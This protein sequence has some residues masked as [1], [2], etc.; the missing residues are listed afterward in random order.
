MNSKHF[1]KHIF[2][3]VTI[4]AGFTA[5]TTF[6]QDTVKPRQ[7]IKEWLTV[8]FGTLVKMK[9]EIIDGEELNDKYHQSSFLFRI[10]SVD[11]ILLPK[12]IIIDFKDET[13]KFPTDEFELYKYLYGKEIG[14]I[15][16]SGS[17]K[18]K[19]KYVGQEFTIVA[20]EAGEFGGVPD[21][22]FRYQPVR[23]DFGFYFRHYIIVVADLTKLTD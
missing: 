4:I 5:K 14:K 22:Y 18:M 6:G 17:K 8:P 7:V 19:K 1:L 20:Y 9:V 23:Q 15:S 2:F 13:G 21:G 3:T 10:K 11:S 16:P 12:S